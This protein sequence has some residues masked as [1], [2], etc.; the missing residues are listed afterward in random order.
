MM[1]NK[2]LELYP[3]F[4][5]EARI[6]NLTYQ[7]DTKVDIHIEKRHRVGKKP[8]ELIEKYETRQIELA[9]VPV[10][11]RSSQCHLSDCN[12][13]QIIRS[14]ECMYDQGGYFIINGSE[15]VIVA[16]ERQACNIVLVFKINLPTSKYAWNAQ[17]RS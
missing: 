15:K 10:M 6:R 13:A 14:K 4:P 16:Q 8:G 9:K 3:Y 12:D 5:H 17:V 2:N 1:I 11:I 7:I